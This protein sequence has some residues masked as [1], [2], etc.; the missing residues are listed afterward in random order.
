MP[1]CAPNHGRPSLFAGC[2]TGEYVIYPPLASQLAVTKKKLLQVCAR[3]SQ[4]QEEL[5]KYFPFHLVTYT[6]LGTNGN[7]VCTGRRRDFSDIGVKLD[8]QC[9][10]LIRK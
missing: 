5:R 8:P 7:L 4:I 1:S 9:V 2:F 6:Y 10:V 3:P